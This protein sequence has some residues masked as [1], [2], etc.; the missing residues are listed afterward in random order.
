MKARA[1]TLALGGAL[2]A[3]GCGASSGLRVEN[4]GGTVPV[5][6][7]ATSTV[8][9]RSLDAVAFPSATH[10]WAAGQ[11]AII[12]TTDGG[13]TWTEQY[14]GSAAVHSLDFTDDRNGWAVGEVSLLRTIDGGATWEQAGEPTGRV[15]TSVDFV[16]PTRG[17]GIA[18][19]EPAGPS[20]G[21]VVGT[22]DG[23]MTWSVVRPSAAN[24]LCT[25]GSTLIAGAGSQ[26]ER[27]GDGGSTWTTLFDASNARTPW[28]GTTVECA[29]SSIWALFQ[30]GAA[31]GSQGYAAYA[32]P[33]AGASWK[34]VVVAPILAGS[35]PAFHGVAQLDNYAGPFAAVT[36]SE[37]VFLGQ[38]PACDPQHVMV[39]RTQDGGAQWERH[40][41]NGFVPTGVAFAD[42]GHGW[43]TTQLGG[44]PGRHAAILATT[45]GGRTWHPVFP[46]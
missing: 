39:L 41:I 21:D 40:V 11:G 27:S 20:L 22:T 33:D 2:V 32:S 14:R 13:R 5:T 15:L 26:V 45:D 3:S 17:W 38:C 10:G 12:A 37:A 19:K 30:G 1:L 16:S 44:Y 24:S 18:V 4:S 8:H 28:F 25:S 29:G 35:D 46:A 7:P 31:A 36:P 6:R 23:G 9:V 34:P 42:S 43:M